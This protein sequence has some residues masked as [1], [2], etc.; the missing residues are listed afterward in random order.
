MGTCRQCGSWSVSGHNHKKVIG[1]TWYTYKYKT[2]SRWL[3]VYSSVLWDFF[4]WGGGGRSPLPSL[5]CRWRMEYRLCA[6]G[7]K[8]T[9]A[10]RYVGLLALSPVQ[11]ERC[12]SITGV[13]VCSCAAVGC[14]NGARVVVKR[15]KATSNAATAICSRLRA[16]AGAPQRNAPVL[17]FHYSPDWSVCMR[18]I[19]PYS[20]MGFLWSPT[21]VCAPTDTS[22]FYPCFLN[23]VFSLSS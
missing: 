12:P 8:P 21:L 2:A 7:V 9:G 16:A 23:I 14:N 6:S 18:R 19:C 15:G 13:W 22:V 17:L 11:R 20:P 5:V 4:F 1:H 10:Y 3:P